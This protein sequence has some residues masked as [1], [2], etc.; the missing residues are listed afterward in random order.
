MP[1]QTAAPGCNQ[2]SP[3]RRFQFRLRTLM[4][5]VTIIF[6]LVLYASTIGRRRLVLISIAHRGGGYSSDPWRN[7]PCYD[8][9]FYRRVLGDVR[10]SIIEM[11]E[12]IFSDDE[13]KQV[14]MM[15]PGALVDR[16]E[17]PA[18]MPVLPPKPANGS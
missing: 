2:P 9:P 10:V 6:L 16:G 8:P 1:N 7:T 12:W 5:G 14:G 11:P 3:R 17:R 15:F 4:I 18:I 13:V